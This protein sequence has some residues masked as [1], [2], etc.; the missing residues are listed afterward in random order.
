MR[1][2]LPTTAPAQAA[3]P[4]VRG[5]CR[6]LRYWLDCPPRR[7]PYGRGARMVGLEWHGSTWPP[8]WPTSSRS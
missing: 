1:S 2:K 8:R 3:T 6:A 7:S 4:P 5:E